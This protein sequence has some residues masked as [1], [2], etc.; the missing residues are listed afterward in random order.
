MK[1]Y[2]SEKLLRFV[3]WTIDQRHKYLHNRVWVH[4]YN[5]DGSTYCIDHQI[6]ITPAFRMA[7]RFENWVWRLRDRIDPGCIPF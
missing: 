1:R 4:I 5:E 2:I 6:N 3:Y 7:V